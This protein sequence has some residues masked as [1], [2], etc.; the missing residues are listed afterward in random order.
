MISGTAALRSAAGWRSG[1]LLRVLAAAAVMLVAVKLVFT[2]EGFLS[3]LSHVEDGSTPA[4]SS[5][6]TFLKEG[7]FPEPAA[8]PADT[9]EDAADAEGAAA[10]RTGGTDGA[11]DPATGSQVDGSLPPLDPAKLTAS[12]IEVLRQLAARRAALEERERRFAERELLL[13]IAEQRLETQITRLTELRAE[14]QAMVEKRDEAEEA[15]IR[16]L[17]KIYE[18]M[19]PKAAAEIFDRLEMPVLLRVV[20]RMR[21]PK[22]A[23]VLGRMDPVKAK[24]VTAELAKRARL[25]RRNPES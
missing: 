7:D 6:E 9:P 18:T 13:Q 1:A 3:A 10:E 5:V 23:E 12:E 17:V 22:S 2:L 20:E 11:S 19:K 15:R 8:G 25:L 14:I 4:A 21:E 24:Q 16:S